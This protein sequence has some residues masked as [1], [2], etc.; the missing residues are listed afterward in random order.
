MGIDRCMAEKLEQAVCDAG[1]QKGEEQAAAIRSFLDSIVTTFQRVRSVGE[2]LHGDRRITPAMR[3]IMRAIDEMGPMTVPQIAREKPVSRQ[4][5]QKQ[6]KQLLDRGYVEQLP[7]PA[8]NTSQLIDL[9]EMGHA[10]LKES[11]RRE[12][13][14]FRHVEM[15]VS[16]DEIVRAVET[17]RKLEK[18]LA[19][20]D[21]ADYLE[22]LEKSSKKDV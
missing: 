10:E 13:T 3:L 15:D 18:H 6:V 4:V 8:H 1:M 7:N 22:N 14:I 9:T 12:M 21:W 5:V 17:V 2:R 16:V 11:N 20:R 19:S